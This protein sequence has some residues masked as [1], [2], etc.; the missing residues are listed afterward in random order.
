MTVDTFDSNKYL[1]IKNL[2]H[3]ALCNIGKYFP[4]ISYF[5]KKF[6]KYE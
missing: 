1:T 6:A 5:A 4:R 2:S 3:I